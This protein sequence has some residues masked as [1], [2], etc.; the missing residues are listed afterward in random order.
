MNQNNLESEL[1]E[2]VIKYSDGLYS[3]YERV[4]IEKY[5]HLHI[6]FGTLIVVREKRQIVGVARWN[7]KS[8]SHAKV[9]DCIIHPDFRRKQIMKNMILRAKQAW[10]SLETI[11][12]NRKKDFSTERYRSLWSKGSLKWQKAEVHK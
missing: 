7:W 4:H 11:S 2:F 3:A 8:P 10:P 1:A 9:L 5:I 12:F 6:Q